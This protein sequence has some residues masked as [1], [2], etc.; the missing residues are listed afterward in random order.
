MIATRISSIRVVVCASPAYLAA[1]GRP[2]TPD[3]LSDHDCIAISPMT[4]SNTWRF[5]KGKREFVSTGAVEARREHVGGGRSRRDRRRRADPGHVLQDG[6]GEA[7][8]TLELVLENFEVESLPVHVVY[9]PR[10]PLPLK[11]RAF[12]DWMTP[13]LKANAFGADGSCRAGPVVTD[14]RDSRPCRAEHDLARSNT[15]AG[16]HSV[17]VPR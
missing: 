15:A 14:L 3:Q 12:I 10:K 9:S 6:R 8:G 1:R 2:Q 4:S 16:R 17:T 13:R 5:R 7:C 11:I